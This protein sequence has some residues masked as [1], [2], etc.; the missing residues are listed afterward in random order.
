MGEGRGGEKGRGA[1]SG[2]ITAPHPTARAPGGKVRQPTAR[3]H[4]GRVRRRGTAPS[5]RANVDKFPTAMGRGGRLSNPIARCPGGRKKGQIL[6]K[7][8]TRVRS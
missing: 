7:I 2:E 3:A 8:Q 1:V 6:K 5:P 4:D